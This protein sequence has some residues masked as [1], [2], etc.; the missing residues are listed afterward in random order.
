MGWYPRRRSV[1]RGRDPFRSQRAAAARSLAEQHQGRRI[2]VT[3]SRRRHGHFLHVVINSVFS[4]REDC[5][6][7]LVQRLVRS[8]ITASHYVVDGPAYFQGTKAPR[9]AFINQVW[10]A[11]PFSSFNKTSQLSVDN[12]PCSAPK[13]RVCHVTPRG[14]LADSAHSP[15]RQKQHNA[16]SHLAQVQD[17]QHCMLFVEWRL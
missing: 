16:V 9:H 8:A 3:Q 7:S 13:R 5:L 4:T 11:A 10:F 2:N 1:F 14:L 6:V 12:R 15:R 17:N